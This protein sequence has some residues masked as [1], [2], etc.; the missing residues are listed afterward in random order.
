MPVAFI[1]GFVALIAF[2]WYI[3]VFGGNVRVVVPGKFY[4]SATITGNNY[5][6]ISAKWINNDLPTVAKRYNI[7]TII[8][9]R[10]VPKATDK[11]RDWYEDEVAYCERE[12]IKR[13][14]IPF[15]SVRLPAPQ[16]LNDILN[17]YDTAEYPVLI[18]CQ[19][20]ADRSG[21]ASVLYAAI[22]EKMPFEEAART[23]L[24]LQYAHVSFGKAR[25]MSEFCDLYRK[26]NNGLGLREWIENSYPTLYAERT[27]KT[28]SI[29]ASTPRQ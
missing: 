29:S 27:Q 11:E 3:G 20:G 12:G 8:N 9:L 22:Y 14:D 2:L 5:T 19:A 17:A 24:T 28:A 15:S 18:H 21:L 26:H 10:Y 25:A 6:S 1:L 23:Q 13:V 16:I 7:R 4:R